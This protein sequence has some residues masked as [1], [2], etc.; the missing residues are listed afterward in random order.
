MAKFKC[1]HSG[2]IYELTEPEAIKSMRKHAEY[3]EEEA[4]LV[5][6]APVPVAPSK[7]KKS[8]GEAA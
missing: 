2:C 4:S 5:I 8:K 7:P 1:V 3:S 6:P